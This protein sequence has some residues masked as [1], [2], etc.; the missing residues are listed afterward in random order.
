MLKQVLFIR[1][2]GCLRPTYDEIG[3]VAEIFEI[4]DREKRAILVT[5]YE[6]LE[7]FKVA[8]F[9]SK[10]IQLDGL[11]CIESRLLKLES[12]ID[13]VKALILSKESE[14]FHKNEK[15]NEIY[16]P[17]RIRTGDLRRVKATS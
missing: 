10:V 12:E 17:G 5:F 4:R 2:L 11:D 7:S 1:L 16:G 6:G 13:A 3:K 9:D 14:R 15:E 8:Q